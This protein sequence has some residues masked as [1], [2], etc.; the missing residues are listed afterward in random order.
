MVCL[1]PREGDA[2]TAAPHPLNKQG[3]AAS[4]A[5]RD[6]QSSPGVSLFSEMQAGSLILAVKSES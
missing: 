1:C 5:Q 3:C 4:C 2:T 6:L